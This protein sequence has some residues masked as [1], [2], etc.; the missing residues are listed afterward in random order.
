M[1]GS[2]TLRSELMKALLSAH[3]N[4]KDDNDY[5]TKVSFAVKGFFELTEDLNHVEQ[6]EA[7][8]EEKTNITLVSLPLLPLE[9]IVSYLDFESLVNLAAVSTYFAH[10]QP[11]EQKVLGFDFSIQQRRNDPHYC[12]DLYF[13]IGL[14]TPGLKRVTMDWSWK[15]QGWGHRKG[16]IWLELVRDLKVVA[17]CKNEFKQLAPHEMQRR[18]MVVE[19]HPVITSAV[20]GDT[21]RVTRNTGGGGGHALYVKD[22]QMTILHKRRAVSDRLEEGGEV[23]D[24]QEGEEAT[25]GRKNWASSKPLVI[26]NPTTGTSRPSSPQW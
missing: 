3:H 25:P 6:D 17:N 5:L 19:D 13:E 1:S 22:F 18:Q 7:E 9:K 11:I 2:A 10:L 16:E 23:E 12:P 21:L 15:D 4:A 20:S 14:I 26:Q 8:K 24:D